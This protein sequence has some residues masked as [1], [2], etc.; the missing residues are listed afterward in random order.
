MLKV[1]GRCYL[2]NI[3][4]TPPDYDNEVSNVSK[5]YPL[6]YLQHGGARTKPA[7]AIKDLPD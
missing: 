3:V 1:N 4:Y 2:F 7:G 6:L 5:R